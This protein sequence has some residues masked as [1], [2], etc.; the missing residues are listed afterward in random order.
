MHTENTGQPITPEITAEAEKRIIGTSTG[1]QR[2]TA[3]GRKVKP[4]HF[5]DDTRGKIWGAIL[6]V[7]DKEGHFEQ[8]EAEVAAATAI[9]GDNALEIV[10]EFHQ[11]FNDGG[12]FTDYSKVILQGHRERTIADLYLSLENA[13]KD[14]SQE[15]I[16]EIAA[17][18]KTLQ[19]NA[20]GGIDLAPYL[21]N[22]EERPPEIEPILTLKD[23][24]IGTAGNLGL[25]SG[26]AKTAKSHSIGA[27]LASAMA[28]PDNLPDCL[29]FHLPNPAEH[30]VIYIDFEQSA[31]DFDT[32]I[33]SS[34]RRAGASIPPPWLQALHLTSQAPT[35]GRDILREAMRQG[36]ES[37][38]GIRAVI[39]DG[40]ADLIASPNDEAESFELV[41]W[42][43]ELAIEHSCLL[44]GVLHLNPSGE[45]F[46]KMRGHLGSQAERKAETVLTLK[47]GSDDVVSCFTS[48]SRHQPIPE[49]QAVRF[50]WDTE[51]GM[52]R[53]TSDAAEVRSNA[54]AEERAKL[55]R[56]VFA[57]NH[58][59]SH[60]DTV[61]R[62][63]DLEGIK[64]DAA[65]KRLGVLRRENFVK[66]QPA[67]G[68]YS[69]GERG[70]ETH[71]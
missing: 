10:Q 4:F 5:S 8:F 41:R 63:V 52:F 9:G 68:F 18:I 11:R 46:Q 26:Q 36:A 64:V 37:F 27:M 54:K 58:A 29:G 43:H 13:V 71:E 19:K 34:L 6:E 31:S 44:L 24:P 51:L 39:V 45:V 60:A 38:G 48:K 15:L 53:T 49:S 1:A 2:I 40:I 28:D 33:R 65:K 35:R 61:S 62:I 66:V 3:N 42:L 70:R 7:A 23:T 30:A 59:L 50:A 57:V 32:L 14:R 55:A 21:W 67:T 20:G 56:D 47:K 17:K 12:H 22:P 25:L 16:D 69:L